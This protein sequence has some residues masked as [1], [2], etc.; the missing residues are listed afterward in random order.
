MRETAL[1]GTEN[2]QFSPKQEAAALA[3]ARGGT[4]EEAARSAGCGLR[5][6]KTWVNLP[7]F[8]V[9]VRALRS[10]MTDRA[11]GELADG[12]ADAARGLRKLLSAKSET[13]RLG[14]CRAML[15][16][17]VKLREATELEERITALENRNEQHPRPR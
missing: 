13:V 11:V 6:L 3:L 16:L 15:E 8:V 12:M 1:N 5:T 14:A 17:T 4:Q 9:R 7:G 2:S 10:A